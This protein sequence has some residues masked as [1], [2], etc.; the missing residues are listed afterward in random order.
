MVKFARRQA[1]FLKWLIIIILV[2]FA[3]L[4]ISLRIFLPN[5]DEAR[6]P[7][8]HWVQKA[9]G[10]DITFSSVTG[11][12][13]L[14]VPSLSLHSLSLSPQDSKQI[15]LTAEEINIQLD[16]WKSLLKREPTFSNISIDGLRLDLTQLPESENTQD[17]SLKM[18]LERLFLVGLG[19]FSVQNSTLIV[20]SSANEPEVIEIES[21]LWDSLAGKHQVEGVLSVQGTS[22]NQVEVKGIFTEKK[23]LST[24]DGDFYLNV[25][26]VS[27]TNWIT[28]FVNPEIAIEQARVDGEIWLTVEKGLPKSAHLSLNNSYL[29]WSHNSS[30]TEDKPISQVLNIRQ[31]NVFLTK[32]AASSWKLV[33]DNL[34]IKTGGR[35]W[36]NLDLKLQFTENDWLVNIAQLDLFL[37]M[38]LRDVFALPSEVKLAISSLSPKGMVQDLRIAGVKNEPL[39]YSADINN[40]TFEHWGYLPEV[41]KLYLSLMGQGM[42]GKIELAMQKDHLPYG[43]FF[44]APL[45]IEQGNVSLYWVVEKDSVLIWSDN[46][47][48]RSPELSV[49]GE[50][51]LELPREGSPW[52]SFYAE[53]NLTNAGEAWRYLPTLALGEE[54]TN[55][56]SAAIRGGKA[57]NAK[58]LWNGD[59][60]TFPYRDLQGIFQAY[61]P[62]SNGEFSFDTDWPMLTELDLD[63]LF[64][65]DSLYLNASN[66]N[67]MGARGFDITGEIASFSDK[68]SMLTIGAKIESSGIIL[69]D[70]MLATP[71]VDSVG[72]ALTHL[73]VDGG[74]DATIALNIPLNGD[75][76]HVEGTAKLKNNTITLVRPRVMLTDFTGNVEFENDIVWA[77][78]ISATLL[79]Q[80]VN[81]EFKGE[82][83]SEDYLV[84][85]KVNANWDANKLKSALAAPDVS[86]ITGRSHWDMAL[87]IALKDTGFT[88]DVD[89]K[90]DLTNLNIDFPAPFTKPLLKKSEGHLKASGDAERLLAQ[91]E[92]PNWK[93]QAEVD[94]TKALPD[95][96]RSQMVIGKGELSL[97]PL[98]GNAINIRTPTLDVVAWKKAWDQYQLANKDN[99]EGL[100]FTLHLPSRVNVKVNK[101]LTGDMTFNKLSM[102]VRNKSG[103]FRIIVG[104]EELA[105]YAWWERGKKLSMS[106]EHLFLNI[107]VDKLKKKTDQRKNRPEQQSLQAEQKLMAMLPSTD[108]NVDELWFQGYRLGKLDATLIKSPNQLLLSRFFLDGGET[109]FSATGKW[110][111]NRKGQ[112]HTRFDFDIEGENSSDLMG[113]FAVSEGIQDASFMSKATLNY[114]G[115]PWSMKVETLDGSVETTLGKGYVSGVG[116]AG[117]LLGLFSLDSILRKI[118]LDFSGVFEDGLAFDGI[119]GTA[120]ITNGVI[121]S[122]NIKMKALAGDMF[123]KGSANLVENQVDADVRFI[124]DLTSG[125]PVFTAFAVTPQTA[126]YVLALTTVISPVIEAFTQVKYRV[127]GPIDD[128]VVKEVSR[129]TSEVTLPERATQRLRSE[130]Q[131]R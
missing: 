69:R 22:L 98:L 3:I 65:N 8:Q 126:L 80:P 20:L 59:F 43:A 93:Y 35:L 15:I 47:A 61:V 100:P 81:L 119:S 57:K 39:S 115:A 58:L 78:G 77:D 51:R 99:H 71:L 105:G 106:I 109:K 50:F 129:R 86:M 62:I 102:S 63:L 14:L 23:G 113:R 60:S 74:M 32:E 92:L 110:G 45:V 27:L 4:T 41:H 31:G 42:H 114:S 26:N 117:K 130:Q 96:T 122:N 124:P 11:H 127:T 5:L 67:L 48:V 95:V 73:Q 97:N 118:K 54:L 88:Y 82:T 75:K 30:L 19:H 1:A 89:L 94:I 34:V 103:V 24:L 121:E 29:R 128:P 28:Q 104:S 37:L 120:L 7:L 56:L 9:T 101:V 87:G 6:A 55:Y 68:K 33:T 36:P 40:V 10:F 125:I 91:I 18:Q 70:Y 64:Q 66:V 72:A 44:Q 38:P 76:V 25:E 84:G 112:S 46:I 108:L 131:G 52:L 2:T 111:I 79:E 49:L 16:L 116:G 90:A 53:A 13:D 17:I 85:I 107:D 12:W 21:L 83:E 123:I